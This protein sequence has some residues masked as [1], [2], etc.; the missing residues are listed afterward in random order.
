MPK[1]IIIKAIHSALALLLLSFQLSFADSANKEGVNSS[2]FDILKSQPEGSRVYQLSRTGVEKADSSIFTLILN[3]NEAGSYLN[4]RNTSSGTEINYKLNS[5]Q[6]SNLVNFEATSQFWRL[7]EH[8]GKNGLDGA[9]W[10]LEGVKANKHHK[11][12]RWSPLPPYYSSI[13][14]KNGEI[15]KDPATPIGSDLKQSDEVGLDMFCII[16]MLTQPNFSED[17]F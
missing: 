2:L 6:V 4:V 3:N 1:T 7:P 15:V 13:M 5:G 9:L 14:D 16:I 8:A 10:Q 12:I 17:L 11:T